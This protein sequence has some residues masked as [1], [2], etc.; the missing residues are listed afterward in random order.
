MAPAVEDKLW[1]DS[2]EHEGSLVW[3]QWG[4]SDSDTPVQWWYADLDGVQ[5]DG[6]HTMKWTHDIGSQ[7]WKARD[8]KRN[9]IYDKSYKEPVENVTMEPEGEVTMEP[10]EEVT[11]PVKNK[12]TIRRVKKN[13]RIEY[14]MGHFGFPQVLPRAYP[15]YSDHP[16]IPF[17]VSDSAHGNVGGG[18][19]P[20]AIPRTMSEPVFKITEM[21][22]R[23]E[24][25]ETT[26]ALPLQAHNLAAGVK[27]HQ[28]AVFGCKTVKRWSTDALERG[29]GR[30]QPRL[31][32]TIQPVRIGP[33]DLEALELTSSMEPIRTAALKQQAEARKANATNPRRSQLWSDPSESALQGNGGATHHGAFESSDG[34]AFSMNRSATEPMINL[35]PARSGIK[36]GVHRPLT[37]AVMSVPSIRASPPGPIPDMTKPREP[38]FFGATSPKAFFASSGVRSGG[39][40]RLDATQLTKPA[41]TRRSKDAPSRE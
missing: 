1:I 19:P 10:E 3:M 26:E 2:T 15:K 35:A 14:D 17:W 24:M 13:L 25:R 12:L 21:A 20:V 33:K 27:A 34:T 40:A 30:N 36:N 18:Y 16:D 11:M 7:L 8:V 38:K 29:I 23:D 6:V 31:F 5:K 22:F 39:F 37:T 4:K 41:A 9:T 28:K 32:D